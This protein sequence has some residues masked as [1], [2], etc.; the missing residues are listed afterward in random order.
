[1]M[2]YNSCLAG[3]LRVCYNFKNE[4]AFYQDISHG[5]SLGHY[6]IIFECE[7]HE[8]QHEEMFFF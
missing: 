3:W 4:I 1:V 8:S 5:G 7:I 2:I 6:L